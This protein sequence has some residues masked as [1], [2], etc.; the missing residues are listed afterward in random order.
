MRM[1]CHNSQVPSATRVTVRLFVYLSETAVTMISLFLFSWEQSW[2]SVFL[3][4]L[5]TVHYY[6][7]VIQLTDTGCVLYTYC[8]QLTDTGRVLYNYCIQLTDTGRVL[9]TYCIQLTDTGRVLYTYCDTASLYHLTDT[10]VSLI[11]SSPSKH[12]NLMHFLPLCYL[13]AL[14]LCYLALLLY[15]TTPWYLVFSHLSTSLL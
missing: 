9:Y 8:I 5:L 1:F 14:T 13:T 3:I 6:M 4:V 12:V 10:A 7:L 2:Y 15:S 11:P